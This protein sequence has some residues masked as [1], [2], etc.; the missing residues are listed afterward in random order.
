MQTISE[1]K[2]NIVTL[3]T[4]D[5]KCACVRVRVCVRVCVCVRARAT[6]EVALIFITE[7]VV[8]F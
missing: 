6:E 5:A 1:R 3:E 7:C 4:Q 8:V 2:A